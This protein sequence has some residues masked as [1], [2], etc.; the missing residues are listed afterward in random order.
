[1]RLQYPLRYKFESLSIGLKN[2]I[3]DRDVQL[4]DMHDLIN[5]LDQIVKEAD[6]ED[7]RKK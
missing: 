7:A 1:M 6:E 3:L 2:C 5:V 4:N